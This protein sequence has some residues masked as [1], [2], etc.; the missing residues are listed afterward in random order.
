[1][2]RSIFYLMLLFFG[3]CNQDVSTGSFDDAGYVKESIPGSD[4]IRVEKMNED[5]VLAEMGY[6]QN[7]LKTGVWTTYWND[8]KRIK[9]LEHYLNGKKNGPFM[10]F[11]DR[12]RILDISHYLNDE[13]HGY[14]V[15]YSWGSP[16]KEIIYNH[17]KINGEMR[18]YYDKNG[19]LQKLVNFNNGVQ[20]GVFK[21]Y[22]FEGNL[23]LEYMYKNGKKVS[24]GP[25]TPETD[26]TVD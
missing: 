1:M 5:G 7:G 12:N 23:I 3:A 24:G 16:S 18:V 22:D 20:D 26:E 4:F 14:H 19:K 13:L 25:V 9:S 6:L 17:G 10:R 11:N 21:Q 2:K 15:T 8:G